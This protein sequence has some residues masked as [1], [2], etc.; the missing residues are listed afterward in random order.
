MATGRKS[1]ELV[2]DEPRVVAMP[3]PREAEFNHRQ[4][5]ALVSEHLPQ[6]WTDLSTDPAPLQ[7]RHEACLLAWLRLTQRHE[8]E[9][10]EETGAWLLMTA[11]I[12]LDRALARH[13]MGTQHA[14]RSLIDDEGATP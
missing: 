11:R 4:W 14:V 2:G 1:D 6:M 5:T 8:I 7:L 3:R 9:S 12:E 13:E 10:G